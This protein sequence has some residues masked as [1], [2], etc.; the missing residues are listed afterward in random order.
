M[1]T[2]RALT[3][4]KNKE[5]SL[6]FSVLKQRKSLHKAS[7]K[8]ITYNR[9]KPPKRRRRFY[10]DAHENNRD[11]WISFPIFRI[12]SR[13]IVAV[14]QAAVTASFIW[15]ELLGVRAP[16]FGIRERYESIGR[17][18]SQGGNGPPRKR[19]ESRQL[20]KSADRHRVS[21]RDGKGSQTALRRDTRHQGADGGSFGH[22]VCHG[23]GD[24]AGRAM[25]F[26]K[27]HPS[28]NVTGEQLFAP[29]YSFTHKTTYDIAVS[30][31]YIS[32][33]DKVLI[34]DDFL[35]TERLEWLSKSSFRRA[36]RWRGAAR[37]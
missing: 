33:E 1:R 27:K 7:L 2:S 20:F 36:R 14:T 19:A 15:R 34:T 23:G 32:K 21:E 28:A 11:Y 13:R 25:V 16:R 29:V 3:L 22:R 5:R 18:N 6:F 30:R 17:K 37:K 10:R 9:Y 4:F 35:E 12:G 24:G 8:K 26:A 31:D